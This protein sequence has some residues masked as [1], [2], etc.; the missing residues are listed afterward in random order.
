MLT[1]IGLGLYDLD[2]ISEKGLKEIRAADHIFLETYTSRLTGTD[3]GAM[4]ALYGKPVGLLGRED[5]EQHPESFLALAR[6]KDVVFLTGGD[7][8]VSTTHIDLRIRAAR[9]G[10]KTRIVHGASI[11]SAV[12]GLTGLQN[13]RFGKSCSL[14]F[15]HGTW[16][17]S[18]PAEVIRQN[19]NEH[20]HTIVYLDIQDTRCMTIREAV[21]LLEPMAE[22]A[23][24]NIP[25]Y[26]G[27]ARAGSPDPVVS[28]GNAE[29]M[30]T[31]YFG[32][33]LHILVVPGELHVME[34]E[35]LEIFAAYED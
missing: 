9:L 32:G 24:F 7:P 3:T 21:D 4:E 31:G 19:L 29:K 17:P 25:C 34:R 12:S 14:P 8:M 22:R 13:Y 15:P 23:G 10:I 1:F 33:P 18:T 28:A 26:I 20:L 6:G 30:R 27:I 2:D 16:C 11:V 5:V 35:Y